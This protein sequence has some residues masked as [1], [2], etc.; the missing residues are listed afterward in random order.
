MN[1]IGSVIYL[2]TDKVPYGFLPCN[3]QEVFKDTN[4]LL[5]RAIGDVFGTPSTPQFFVLPDLRPIVNGERIE[6]PVVG[7]EYNGITWLLP[8]ICGTN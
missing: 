8:C 5:Y 3:G 1:Q 7:E 4:F 6:N 2:A